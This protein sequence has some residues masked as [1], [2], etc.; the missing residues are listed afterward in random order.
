MLRALGEQGLEVEGMER[1]ADG[2]AKTGLACEDYGSWLEYGRVAVQVSREEV[3]DWQPR[4]RTPKLH[5]S[6]EYGLRVGGSDLGIDGTLRSRMSKL[7]ASTEHGSRV[8]W[9]EGRVMGHCEAEC[10]SFM[11]R[12][13]TG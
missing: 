10:R 4:S 2:T 12:Q 3:R 11:L 8:R 7:D 13:N 9:G 5:A 1:W 6:A